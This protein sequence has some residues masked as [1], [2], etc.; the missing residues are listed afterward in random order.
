M[1]TDFDNFNKKHKKRF[2]FLTLFRAWG[3]GFI[4]RDAGMSALFIFVSVGWIKKNGSFWRFKD[5]KS[6]PLSDENN[7]S[8]PARDTA[9]DAPV[10]SEE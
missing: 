5:K 3:F 4:I 6:L 9:S 2:V 10:S 7:T 8:E 1:K